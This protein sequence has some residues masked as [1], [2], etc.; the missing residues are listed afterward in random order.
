M[1]QIDYERLSV[2]NLWII[3]AWEERGEEK[4][5]KFKVIMEAVFYWKYFPKKYIF[6]KY[7]VR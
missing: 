3:M 5:G 6:C 2:Y 4:K 7:V 1:L